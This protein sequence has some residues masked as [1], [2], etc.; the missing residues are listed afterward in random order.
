MEQSDVSWCILLLPY[1][2]HQWCRI[3]CVYKLLQLLLSYAHHLPMASVYVALMSGSKQRAACQLGDG[4]ND[5]DLISS[6]VSKRDGIGLLT[7]AAPARCVS[8]GTTA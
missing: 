5:D 6:N 3:K 7:S 8:H 4:S 2:Q 1:P